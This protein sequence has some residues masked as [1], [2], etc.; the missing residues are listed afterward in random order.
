MTTTAIDRAVAARNRLTSWLFD[1]ALP[2][3]SSRGTDLTAGGFFETISPTGKASDDDRRTR[4]VG[5]QIFTFATAGS[6]GWKGPAAELVRHGVDYLLTNCRNTDGS[7]RSVTRPGGTVV[8]GRFDLYDHAF[9]L[10]GLAAAHK[11]LGAPKQLEAAGEDILAAAKRGWS[12]P[13]GGF[14][15]SDP[16]TLPLKANPHMH[17]FEASL[18]WEET[19]NQPGSVWSVQA[20][21]IGQLALENFIRP[22]GMLRE[23]FDG[24]WQPM[25]YESGRIVEPGHQFEWAWL[26]WR[27]D[28][29]R[30]RT[31]AQPAAIRLAETAEQFGVDK[32]R[33]LAIME[34]LD[35][36]SVKDNR[37]RLWQQTERI[38]CWLAMA[39]IA[40]DAK[41]KS[42]AYDLV[43]RA[44]AGLERYLDYPVEGGAFEFI[45][46]NGDTVVDEAR[47]SSMYHII[48]AV[49]EMHRLLGARNES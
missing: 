45:D 15:E 23:F 11:F 32:V 44:A 37:A 3:W 33:D 21:E 26:L 36:L 7:V 2:L 19:L 4:V 24:N 40:P 31:S 47:A 27:W 41:E 9:A 17:M 38:K 35:D 13:L 20:D 5:R 22:D 25:P 1:K 28:M 46:G 39:E 12:H 14:E 10:F 16:R 48:C 30:G 43:A 29:A 18:A 34:I 6:M 42:V 8:D 49:S